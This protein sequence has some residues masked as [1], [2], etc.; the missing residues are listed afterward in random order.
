MRKEFP[1]TDYDFYGYLASGF[2]GLFAADYVLTG[3]AIML[4]DHWT[5][6]QGVLAFAV[7]YALGQVLASPSSIF[8][9]HMIAR[10]WLS[11]PTEI[12]AGL[13]VP[14]DAERFVGEWIIGRNYAPFD[15]VTRQRLHERAETLSGGK[16]VSAESLFQ[17]SFN[18]ARAIDSAAKRLDEFRNVYGLC[19]NL[20]FTCAITAIA[21]AVR[22]LILGDAISW[23]LAAVSALLSVGMLFRFLKF[24]SA[25]AAE[26]L[27]AFAY[28]QQKAP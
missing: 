15:E 24:Y 11:P 4:R 3:G 1:F 22:A 16:A 28:S 18:A 10:R 17:M 6:V 20:A 9:E 26:A 19:R 25:F 12:L 14:T 13:K 23:S 7:A 2:V 21:F 27:R 5:F 8:I